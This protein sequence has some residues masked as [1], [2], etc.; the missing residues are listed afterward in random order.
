MLICLRLGH[1][2][3]AEQSDQVVYL[4]QQCILRCIGGLLYAAS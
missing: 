2:M 4:A 3:A 1:I